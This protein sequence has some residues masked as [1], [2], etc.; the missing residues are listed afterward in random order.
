MSKTKED[1][2]VNEKSV[3]RI[4]IKDWPISERPREKMIAHGAES[5]TD[6]ELLALM[7]Q[8]GRGDR[9]ALD[10]ARDLLSKYRDLRQISRRTLNELQSEKGIGPARAVTIMAAFEI[11]K[12]NASL[13]DEGSSRITSPEDV[14]NRYIPRLRDLPTERFIALMLN[15]SGKIVREFIVSEGTVN[16]SL[17]HPREVFKAAVTELATA[18]IL[19]HNHPSGVKSASKED[20]AITKQLVEAGKLMDIPVQDHI[21]IC[22]NSYISFAE[23]GW[24]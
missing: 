5:L 18:V 24:L 23:N 14:A 9:T 22:G 6:A 20:H 4:P 21:I 17:V 7:I 16:A 1:E 12:R 19:M 10:I 13:N 3:Y 2:Q 8:S 11:G 15:N